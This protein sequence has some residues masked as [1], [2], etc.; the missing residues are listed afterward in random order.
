[1]LKKLSE[2]DKD[3]ILAYIASE[4]EMNLFIYGDIASYGVNKGPVTTYFNIIDNKV[5]SLLLRFSHNYVV[6]ADQ[7]NYETKDIADEIRKDNKATTITGKY[8][9]VEYLG[10]KEFPTSNIVMTYMCS[11]TKKDIEPQVLPTGYRFVNKMNKDIAKDI[12]D[13]YLSIPSFARDYRN[14]SYEDALKSTII[15]IVDS[16]NQTQVIYHDND[17]VS[18][19]TLSAE[20]D[21]SAMVVGVAT[22][23]KYRHLGMARK[24]VLEMAR[25]AFKNKKDF[26]CL[27]YDDPEAGAMYKRIGFQEVGPY[28]MLEL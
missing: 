7:P 20:S 9:V 22:S 17:L 24:N 25:L 3:D 21:I 15:S 27:F 6:Y 26:L 1:M 16:K 18:V 23:I 10:Q 12:L 4:P 14:K 19:I 5:D 2:T 28:A 13:L 11:L 8:S